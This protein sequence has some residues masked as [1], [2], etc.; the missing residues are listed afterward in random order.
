MDIV[1]WV[2]VWAFYSVPLVFISAFVVVPCYFYYYGSVVLF[3]VKHC[4]TSD[5]AC[6]LRIALAIQGLWYFHINFRIDFSI[7]V[8]NLIRILM[9]IAFNI[10][11]NIYV[12]YY[13]LLLEV[14]P[15]SQY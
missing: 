14:Q 3:E 5:V 6:L 4:D 13:I 2:C 12:K 7:S 8:K 1:V 15:F 11:I 10:Y 9:G